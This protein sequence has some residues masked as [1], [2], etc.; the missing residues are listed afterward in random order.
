M[1]AHYDF[2]VIRFNDPRP[3]AKGFVANTSFQW[4]NDAQTIFAFGWK[5]SDLTETGNIEKAIICG[6]PVSLEH[7]ISPA[8]LI[9][10]G[11]YSKLAG[12]FACLSGFDDDNLEIISDPWNLQP[13][14]R[15]QSA[16]G[17][18]C[19]T[20]ADLV[21][22][23]AEKLGYQDAQ[24]YVPC[25]R[26][27][28]LL[29]QA[30]RAQTAFRNVYVVPYGTKV[31]V[32][33][34]GIRF[35]KYWNAD[36]RVEPLTKSKAREKIADIVEGQI[37]ALKNLARLS[38]HPLEIDLTGGKDS[39]TILAMCHKGGLL[40]DVQFLTQGLPTF[41]DVILGTHIA[42]ALDLNYVVTDWLPPLHDWETETRLRTL[43]GFGRRGSLEGVLPKPGKTW[44][45]KGFLGETW[46]TCYPNRPDP[47][48]MNAVK[49]FHR[50]RLVRRQK[51]FKPSH[52]NASLERSENRLEEYLKWWPRVQD[53]TEMEYT[54]QHQKVYYSGRVRSFDRV[55]CH[56]TNRKPINLLTLSG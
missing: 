9:N 56:Y 13:L 46:R 51:F 6:T 8:Q 18:I 39:R 4:N 21:A 30:D 34:D 44:R 15:F 22:L 23:A 31:I 24:L 47:K 55:F 53:I 37:N 12:P 48:S 25:V 27:M 36:W 45:I 5:L 19:G 1:S 10:K 43:E 2:L 40:K 42:R 17:D 7:G 33:S 35:P 11:D 28:V 14:F 29:G 38:A 50:S 52:F 32:K 3:I 49:N 54:T 41:P 26:Q 16:K 20:R